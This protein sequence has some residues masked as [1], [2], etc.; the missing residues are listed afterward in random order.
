MGCSA[1]MAMRLFGTILSGMQHN[2]LYPGYLHAFQT[3]EVQICSFQPKPTYF[4]QLLSG[5][6]GFIQKCPRPDT[7]RDI[8]QTLKCKFQ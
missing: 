5:A 3:A 6:P 8:K 1:V 2:F 4:V 7:P